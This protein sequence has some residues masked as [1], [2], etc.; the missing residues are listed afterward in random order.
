MGA[1]GMGRD[2]GRSKAGLGSGGWNVVLGVQTSLRA[3]GGPGGVADMTQ[4][5]F[6]DAALH[7]V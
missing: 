1:W 7:K 6:R 3:R 5:V 2:W 4:C